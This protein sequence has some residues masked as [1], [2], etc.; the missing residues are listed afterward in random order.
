MDVQAPVIR[1]YERGEVKPSIRMAA[2]M[3]DGLGVS[4]DYLTGLSD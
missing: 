3:A 2:R 1:R 4:L